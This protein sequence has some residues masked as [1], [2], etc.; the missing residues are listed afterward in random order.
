MAAVQIEDL[1]SGF[2]YNCPISTF[3]GT[4]PCEQLTWYSFFKMSHRPGTF[5]SALINGRR[6]AKWGPFLGRQVHGYLAHKKQ[7]PLRTLQ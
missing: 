2:M 6:H 1:F 7:R 5:V 4:H 3:S